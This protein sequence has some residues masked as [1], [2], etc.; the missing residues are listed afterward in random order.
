MAHSKVLEALLLY[1]GVVLDLGIASGSISSWATPKE[2]VLLPGP[3]RLQPP[4]NYVVP[5]AEWSR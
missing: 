2:R 5:M 4:V 3:G 1:T